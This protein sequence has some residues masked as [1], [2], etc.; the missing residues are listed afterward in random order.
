MILN[1]VVQLSQNVSLTITITI[2]SSASNN[3]YLYTVTQV[4]TYVS[5]FSIYV[6]GDI[7]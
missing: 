3:N 2:Q 7:A 6:V 1:L 5:N 4:L